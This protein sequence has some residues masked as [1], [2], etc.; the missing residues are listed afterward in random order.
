MTLSTVFRSRESSIMF[1]LCTAIPLA[2]LSGFSWPPESI[3][4]WL[5]ALSMLVPSTSAVGRFHE[6]GAHGC[7]LQRY[8]LRWGTLWLLAVLYFFCAV[9]SFRRIRRLHERNVLFS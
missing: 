4:H 6:A 5:R 1:L 9:F 8:L 7:A 3:P 2:M